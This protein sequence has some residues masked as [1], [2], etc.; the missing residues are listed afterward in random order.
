[1]ALA[2]VVHPDR[3]E[4]P[5][6]V[7][8]VGLVKTGGTPSAAA[9]PASVVC[10]PRPYRS[11]SFPCCSVNGSTFGARR[12]RSPGRRLRPGGTA[13]RACGRLGTSRLFSVHAAPFDAPL[14]GLIQRS[15]YQ[16]PQSLATPKAPPPAGRSV[17]RDV[18]HGDHPDH[19]MVLIHDRQ[20]HQVVV[21]HLRATSGRSASVPHRLRLPLGDLLGASAARP[22][23]RHHLHDPTACPR[24]SCAT[25]RA[26]CR[27]RCRW[28]RCFAP[29]PRRS[30]RE[31][32]EHEPVWV[33]T[34][35][36]LPDVARTMTD[37]NLVMLPVLDEDHRMVGGDR[38]ST[39]S[40][41]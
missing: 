38:P 3:S 23:Q 20:H 12:R 13:R 22:Q 35:A 32:A 31:I 39:T 34:D 11:T 24:C 1:M 15:A 28:S 36:D 25:P 18:I 9:A 2:A 7:A 29:M 41:S 14:C 33:G 37:Y 4:R 26:G 6:D 30:S 19:P 5:A 21:G 8:D 27:G 10:R 17:C 16:P 40:S